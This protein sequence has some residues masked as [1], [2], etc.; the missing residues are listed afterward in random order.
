MT[1]PQI[2]EVLETYGPMLARIAASYAG[3]PA[4]RDDL[5]QDISIALWRALPQWRGE[6]ALRSFVA[7]V[8]NNRAINHLAA[9]RAALDAPL[10]PDLA[11]PEADPLQQVQIGQRR[12]GLVEAVRGLPLAFRQPVVLAL[13]G[14][15]QKEIAEL[16]GLA[17]NTV[18]QRLSRARRRLRA[19]MGDD[20]DGN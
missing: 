10:D 12:Q 6:S 18:A 1:R 8:A 5:L 2:E 16:L 14:F 3:E 13:E 15:T 4:R 9:N 11:D 17:E 7:R 20:R 19:Q